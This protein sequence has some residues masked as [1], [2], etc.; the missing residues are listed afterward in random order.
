MSIAQIMALHCVSKQ[1]DAQNHLLSGG[2]TLKR[3]DKKG[4]VV[5][6]YENIPLSV[7]DIQMILSSLTDRQIEVADKLQNFMNTLCL[8]N[9]YFLWSRIY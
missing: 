9:P 1:E 7:S 5:A 8:I 4:K 6:D 2:M 3:I